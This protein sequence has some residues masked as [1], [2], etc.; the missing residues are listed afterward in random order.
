[1]R[2][3]SFFRM[4]PS[5]DIILLA[6]R[7]SKVGRGET[8]VRIVTWCSEHGESSRDDSGLDRVQKD[9]YRHIK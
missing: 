3:F 6:S 1:M 8:S 4:G 2:G 9:P 7:T 5:D